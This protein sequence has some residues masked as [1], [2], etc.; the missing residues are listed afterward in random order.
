ME[1]FLIRHAQSANNAKP[2]EQRVPDPAITEI[3]EQ[4]AAHLAARVATLNLTR[5]ITSPFLR[6]LQTTEPVR[7]ATGL[8]PE[9]RIQ[10]HE[11]GGC[12]SGHLPST[13]VGR[14]GL[15]RAEIEQQFPG[16]EIEPSLDGEGWWRSQPY[17]TYE[18]ARSRARTL[19]ERT[20]AEF[21]DTSERVAYIMHADIKM[22]VVD[23]I[24]DK[25]PGV[26]YNTSITHVSVTSGRMQLREYGQ[27][28]HLPESLMT[29]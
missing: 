9:V 10:L 13:K 7:K 20:Q 5:L 27:V 17:E 11:Q 29:W 26:P 4:Q 16:F 24:H 12:Y 22:L 15:N 19:V 28:D 1:L 14:P 2:E 23:Q 18:Q 25:S 8:V 3:G 6:T 21:A